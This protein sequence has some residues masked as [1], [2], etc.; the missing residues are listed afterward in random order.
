[1][2][3]AVA[4]VAAFRQASRMASKPG[5]S[6]RSASIAAAIGCSRPSAAGADQRRHCQGD[7]AG[8]A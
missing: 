5:P 4:A 1:M 7:R 8:Q 2:V 6:A 3:A